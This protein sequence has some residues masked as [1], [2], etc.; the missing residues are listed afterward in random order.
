MML[1]LNNLEQPYLIAEIGINHN[2]DL[3]IAKKLIDAAFACSW[4]C[5][6]FQKRE[7]D[8]CVPEQQKGAI[9][10]TPW[11]TMTYI[12]YKHRIEFSRKEYDYIDKYCKE[13]P[14]SWSASVWDIPSME[15]IAGYDVP[16]IKLPSAMLVKK[17]LLIMAC[18]TGKPIILST[19]MS[20]LEEIDEAVNILSKYASQFALMHANSAYPAP[21]EEL[22]IRC[23]QT[24]KERYK[25]E[26]GYSGHEYG[27]EPTIFAVAMGAQLIERHITIDHM[28]WGTDQS[29]SVEVMGMDMLRK[30]IKDART[31]LGDGL[32]VVTKSEIS[33]RN[34]L[35]GA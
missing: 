24:L 31:I 28:M 34:K 2:G 12:E 22:N 27:L 33:I 18:R 9:R 26:V 29:S 3:Q 30:R 23:I 13:K 32:K 8:L 7:P 14:L 1:D 21:I 17:D 10:E 4:D 16:F 20:T 11:G 6:K 15:F 25:C 19:G 35:R 5:V